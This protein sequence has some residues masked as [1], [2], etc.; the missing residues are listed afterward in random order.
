MTLQTTRNDIVNA[1]LTLNG[2]KAIEEDVDGVVLELA[3][4]FLDDMVK[5]WQAAGAHLWTTLS[6]TLFLEKGQKEYLIGPGTTDHA[7]ETFEAT[8]VSAD[9]AALQ[10]VISITSTTNMVN[11]D[12]IGIELDSGAIHWTTVV[13]FV[14]DTTVT[15][16]TGIPTASSSA[17]RIYYYTTDLGRALK[18]PD[19]RR[20]TQTSSA[21]DGQEIQLY[22][23]ARIDYLQ[24]PNKETSGTPTQYYFQALRT[25]GNLF[26]WPV[27]DNADHRFEFTFRKPLDIFD[28]ASDTADFPNEWLRAL[29]YNLAVATASLSGMPIRP[30]VA[31]IAERTYQVVMAFDQEDTPMLLTPSRTRTRG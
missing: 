29:K 31:S 12:Q 4:E 25:N 7:T 11:A 26:I 5:E 30:D 16:T 2:T 1:A 21:A 9:E 17:N 14:A 20:F 8:T 23:S 27:P 13:S 6:A 10:T 3:A 22:S 18:I 15:I 19:A 24:L 28:S